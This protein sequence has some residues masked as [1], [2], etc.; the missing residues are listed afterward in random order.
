MIEVIILGSGTG[1]PSLR[2]GAPGMVVMVDSEPLLF[3][4]GSGTLERL[5]RAGIAY[6]D[7]NYVFYSHTHNDHTADLGPLLFALKSTPGYTRERPLHLVGPRGFRRFVRHLLAFYPWCQ[8]ERYDLRVHELMPGRLRQS[9][10]EVFARPTAHTDASIAYR[11]EVGGKAIVYSGDTGMCPELIELSKGADLLVLESSYPDG[12]GVEGH[13]TPG[14]AGEVAA[15]AGA[16]RL[17]LTHFYP[18]CDEYDIAAQCRR[19]FGG[20]LIVAQDLMR[21]EVSP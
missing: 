2:R 4:S 6:Q 21:V 15:L 5:L 8:P 1:V 19:T 7:L 10:W 13:L 9:D 18:L 16:R 17:V 3:D 12:L 20:E 11:L 14:R